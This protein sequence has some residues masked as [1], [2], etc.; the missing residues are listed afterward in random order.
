MKNQNAA[1]LLSSFFIN[2]ASLFKSLLFA[3]L[4]FLFC[5]N[6]NAQQRVVTGKVIDSNNEEL[7]GVTIQVKGTTLGVV[8]G[9]DGGYSI[10]VPSENSTLIFSYIGYTTLEIETDGRSLINITME[11]DITVL[12]EVVVTGY[13]V[14]KKVSVTGAVSSVK[15][16][17][18][19]SIPTPTL[20]QSL[21]GKT[22]GL[23][24]KTRTAQ[25]GDYSGITY[26]VRG[27]GD[28]LII[29]DGME[30]TNE[31]FLLLDPN[32][33]DQINI[34]KDAATAAVYGARAGNGVILVKTKRGQ[35]GAP[36]FNYSFN[37]GIQ[38]ITQIPGHVN[39]VQLAQYENVAAMNAGL[40]PKWTNEEIDKFKAGNDPDYPSTDWW[41]LTLRK[42][43]PQIQHNLTVQGGTDKVK[44]FVS[45]GYYHQSSL[46]RSNDLHNK[47]FNLRSNLDVALTDKLDFGLDLSLLNNNVIGPTWNMGT[48]SHT[49]YHW[50][51]MMMLYRSRPQYPES[52]PDITKSV[53]MGGDDPNPVDPS[54]IDKVGYTK[55]DALTS[56]M[57]ATLSYKLP[58]GF[59]LKGIFNLKAFYETEKSKAKEGPVYYMTEDTEGNIKYVQYLTYNPYNMIKEDYTRSNNFNQQYFLT[60]A[61]SFGDHTL[62]ALLVYERLASQGT[63][64]SAQ[65]IRYEYDLDY[66]FAGPDLDKD[67]NGSG[68]EDG[69]IGQVFTLN[70]NY[71]EKYLFGFSARRD[72][73][74]R[75]AED[76]RWGIFPSLSVGWRI[77]Q[78]SFMQS[79][80]AI[81]NLKLRLSA[82]RLGYDR[83]GSFQYLSTYSIQ[84]RTIVVDGVVKSPIRTDGVSNPNITWE[85]I[86]TY[87]AGLDFGL[88]QNMFSGSF[89]IFYR[90]RSDVLGTV[91][92][93]LP[94]IVGATMPQ[95]NINEYSNRGFEFELNYNKRIRSVDFR[96]GG[97]ISFSREKI[98]WVSQP[99]YATEEIRRR[100]NRIGMWSDQQWGYMSDG[101]FLTQEEI[102]NWAVMDN[103]NNA[104]MRVGDVRIID[105]NEDGIITT[106]DQVVI[107][108]GTSPD[109]TYALHADLNWKGIGLSMLWQGAALYD[110]YYGSSDLASPF[111]GG[112]APL[113]EMY[114]YS[115]TPEN[116][117]GAP[118][119][120]ERYP[121]HPKYYAEGISNPSARN[122]RQSDFYYRP[123]SYIR[124]KNVELSYNL[125][126][127]L[128]NFAKIN[129]L[130]VYL[131]GYN[132]LTFTKL[133]FL[134]PEFEGRSVY[135][136]PPTKTYSFGMVVD[137]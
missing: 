49:G 68:W 28:A 112:N 41:D 29:I 60:W 128:T 117:W 36:K 34:L 22:T 24:I 80:P 97:N 92:T 77:S 122:A 43:A 120:M 88:M 47:K 45:G 126:S 133:K 55:S 106:D 44:Y 101:V 15:T 9:M 90:Y 53:G 127:K 118:V 111:Y 50:G 137:F 19:K 17:E 82:G 74:P 91:Q 100:N 115:Y 16:E 54:R 109:I 21:M 84:P 62:D 95:E 52:F 18:L 123:G 46:Y 72:G 10:Q 131:S 35:E 119:N 51:I 96:A 73:S 30:V 65:R 98:E 110:V 14:Q 3:V 132:I 59:G 38:Q 104:Q 136:H 93:S 26:N 108:R 113:L 64:N 70:Y 39:S 56:D 11:G 61:G 94:D 4:L 75:F 2:K 87:N 105:Y 25:P 63:T 23:F 129:N 12:D 102:D 66:L 42:S 27:F 32:D 103:K 7:V 33:I 40:A 81:N 71:K 5:T 48:S 67:N 8:S 85:K 31:E 114:N 116:E 79:L 58:Y 20:A 1:L 134:D 86:T 89:D 107:G 124:L 37:Y 13:G 130:R 135:G 125:S 69:R 121:L 76:S 83:A 78:E 99:Q 6:A 57:K